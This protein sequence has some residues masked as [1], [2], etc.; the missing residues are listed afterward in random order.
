ML[1]LYKKNSGE[2]RIVQS[3]HYDLMFYIMLVDVGGG[4]S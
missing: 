4:E 2:L 3:K 1:I